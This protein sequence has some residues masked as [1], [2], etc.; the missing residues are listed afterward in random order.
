VSDTTQPTF[1]AFRFIGTHGLPLELVLSFLKDHGQ[2]IA[3]D[4]FVK[5]ALKDCWKPRTIR[6]RI[7]AA[8]GDVY[9]PEYVKEWLPRM[10]LLLARMS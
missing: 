1:G 6:A 9:G 7:A 4:D 8:V 5:D 2:V 10:D 3:W